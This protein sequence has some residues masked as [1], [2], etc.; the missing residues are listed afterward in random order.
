MVNALIH[1]DYLVMGSERRVKASHPSSHPLSHPTSHP[2]QDEIK[3]KILEYC[4][5]PR[6]SREIMAHCGYT[7][8]KNF[9]AKYLLPL[10]SMGRI[11]MTL[12]NEPTSRFQKYVTSREDE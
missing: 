1:R 12:P 8:K 5:T 6:S 2:P 3:D 4:T 9:S 7:N 10:V 11:K